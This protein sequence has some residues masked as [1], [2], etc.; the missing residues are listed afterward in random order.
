LRIIFIPAN[1]KAKVFFTGAWKK[2]L[3][4]SQP[5][6]S[7]FEDR[8][9]LLDTVL[10]GKGL[11]TLQQEILSKKTEL[12]PSGIFLRYHPLR[13]NFDW[14]PLAALCTQSI[15]SFSTELKSLI[16]NIWSS[17]P[18]ASSSSV[19][20]LRDKQPDTRRKR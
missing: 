20:C 16:P 15:L 2:E 3:I 4:A 11:A 14:R 7:R 10:P 13:G 18:S 5:I 6:L 19:Q 8:I 9:F 1:K 17:T 12:T